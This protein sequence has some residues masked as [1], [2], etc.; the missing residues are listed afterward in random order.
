MQAYRKWGRELTD[1]VTR[2]KFEMKTPIPVGGWDT[3]DWDRPV[4]VR[5]VGGGY[6]TPEEMRVRTRMVPQPITWKVPT[7][8]D[9]TLGGKWDLGIQPPERVRQRTKPDGGRRGRR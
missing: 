1:P 3:I 7:V 4:G 8:D 5:A 9:P 6:Y 2:A